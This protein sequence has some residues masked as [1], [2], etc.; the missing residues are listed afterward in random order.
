MAKV[1]VRILIVAVVFVFISCGQNGKINEVAASTTTE[2]VV[3]QKDKRAE[4]VLAFI[5]G[6]VDN[7]NKLNKAIGIID[8]VNLDSLTTKSFKTEIKKI[9]DEA[10]KQDPEL[11]LE[12]DP[13][14]DAQDYP[15]KGFELESIDD[16]T[17]FLI[18]KGKDW[19]EFK[20]TIKVVEENG[21]WLVDGC[22]MVNIPIERRVE[23]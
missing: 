15:S 10:N 20:L 14:F 6:Y 8:W 4:I 22:G 11:G 5:N 17:N 19:P 1:I 2:N 18:V 21:N 3:S 7:S 13:I 12:A 16:K 23:R 9:V